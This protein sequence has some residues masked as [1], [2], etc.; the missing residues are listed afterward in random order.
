MKIFAISL[1]HKYHKVVVK[2]R[3]LLLRLESVSSWCKVNWRTRLFFLWI[4]SN[5]SHERP[6]NKILVLRFSHVALRKWNRKSSKQNSCTRETLDHLG[7]CSC[8]EVAFLFDYAVVFTMVA[9]SPNVR[10]SQKNIRQHTFAGHRQF[11]R[12][13]CKPVFIDVLL[14]L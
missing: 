2:Q 1:F 5:Y 12:L 14:W 4:F 10:R 8:A 3:R 13:S 9:A 11:D 6:P 7:P